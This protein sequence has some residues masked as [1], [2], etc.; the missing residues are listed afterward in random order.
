MI[1][2]IKRVTMFTVSLA[3]FMDVLDTN[4]I[5]TAI[6][7]MA[8]NF[9]V[10]PVDLKV[11]LIS[12]LLS[13]AV[14]IPISGWV[15]DKYGTKRIYISALCLF[16]ISSFWCGYAHTLMDLVIGRSFQG[17]GG[18]FMISLGRL[19]I[20]RTFAK[21]QLVGAMNTVIVVVSLAVMLGPFVG[22]IIIE[23]LSWPW[24]FWVNIPAG[25]LAIVL[26]V[27]GLK[28]TAPKKARPFDF[29]G[30]VLF[31]GSLALL[32]FSLSQLSEAGANQSLTL[33][34]IFV[35]LFTFIMYFFIAKNHPH[36]VI[37]TKLFRFRTFRIS[38]L[39]NLFSRLGFGGVPFLLPLF[40]QI[41]LGFSAQLSGL[42]LVPI[43][44]GI[45]FSKLLAFRI[46]RRVGY[47]YYLVIN[48]LFMGLILA[49]FQIINNHTS[50][51]TI[52]C[53]TF[54]F[55]MFTAAQFT[56]MNSLAFAEISPEE[57]SDSTSITST[58]QVLAQTFG[59]AVGAILLRYYS[60]NQEH[61]AILTTPVFHQA[62]FAMSIITMISLLIFMQLKVDD[63]QQMLVEET[64]S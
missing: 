29:L 38:V 18:A 54:I 33:L 49:L 1:L 40:Q 6:P 31:G 27:Y 5:N 10:N 62:F 36:P 41:S 2:S 16:T 51:Y 43:A 3:L 46:L 34:I 50:V 45:I 32:C 14:F 44:F 47:K 57:L 11:A 42:L 22:G 56:A 30:F 60:S 8:H 19:I 12:Y 64:S 53:L 48:T 24:I 59:V 20:A 39:G 63:G 9:K 61:P 23:Q 25:I 52:A 26:G 58:T 28:D 17:V 15:A 13:L 21:H 7:T 4:I 35:A 55:G 37:N